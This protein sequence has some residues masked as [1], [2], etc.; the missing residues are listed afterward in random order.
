M[1]YRKCSTNSLLPSSGGLTLRE[2]FRLHLSNRCHPRVV[3][4]VAIAVLVVGLATLPISA[5]AA[6]CLRASLKGTHG[7]QST[8]MQNNAVPPA[9]L[10]LVG[11]FPFDGLGNALENFVFASSNGSVGQDSASITY[12]VAPD[13]TFSTTVN[14][15][16]GKGVLGELISWRA[17]EVL[18]DPYRS[19]GNVGRP[20][21]PVTHF[22]PGAQ[23]HKYLTT[24]RSSE[25]CA[26]LA[27]VLAAGAELANKKQGSQGE[28][29]AVSHRFC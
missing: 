5:H 1:L 19:K 18:A 8:V 25:R 15:G 13:C 9:F 22:A 7:L 28:G 4:S 11:T 20:T 2:R 3:N 17:E 24:L 26:R 29:H 16:L 12:N 6:G 14:I 27:A 23:A 21:G 10:E